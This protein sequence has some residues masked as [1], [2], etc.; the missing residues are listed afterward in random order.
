MTDYDTGSGPE[1][2]APADA[3]AQT[4][5]VE[6][7]AGTRP[8]Q[9]ASGGA[10]Y[11]T[12]YVMDPAT[13]QLY[14]Q[15]PVQPGPMAAGPRPP[16]EVPP[17]AVP[18]GAASQGPVHQEVPPPAPDYG[19]VIKSV[20]QFAE[21]EATVG[22]VVKTLYTNTAQ[23]D[24]FWKGALVGA[25]VAVLVTSG[26]VKETMGKTFGSLFGA[27]AAADSAAGAKASEAKSSNAKASDA[28][29]KAGD[30]AASPEDKKE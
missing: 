6:S 19:E 2:G 10:P 15:V 25:A 17:G 11:G 9:A 3:Q 18:P 30:T 23:D 26:P 12:G 4:G 7:A 16:G 28:G 8:E 22:D 5:P 27:Q 29:N 21:G 24:Q 13:G 14:Y 1:A 20:E